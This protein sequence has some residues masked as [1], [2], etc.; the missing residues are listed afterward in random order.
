M[1]AM[2]AYIRCCDEADQLPEARDLIRKL[3]LFAFTQ[4]A[5]WRAELDTLSGNVLRKLDQMSGPIDLT[6]GSELQERNKMILDMSGAMTAVRTPL[7]AK[8]RTAQELLIEGI[9]P[10]TPENP[11]GSSSSR[12]PS[13]TLRDRLK[14]IQPASAM[15]PRSTPVALANGASPA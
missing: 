7:K 4:D 13:D 1:D 6:V 11:S 12:C 9:P 2:T 10:V 15:R 8:K 14:Q 3:Q 5:D